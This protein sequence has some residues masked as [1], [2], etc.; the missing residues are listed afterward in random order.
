MNTSVRHPY[1]VQGPCHHD[2]IHSHYINRFGCYFR[3]C[4]CYILLLPAC[5]VVMRVKRQLFDR[6]VMTLG[7]GWHLSDAGWCNSWVDITASKTYPP[8][9]A[10]HQHIFFYLLLLHFP[11]FFSSI[12]FIF[13]PYGL[14]ER[15]G[16]DYFFKAFPFLKKQLFSLIHAAV[17][18]GYY[19][20]NMV[21]PGILTEN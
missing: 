6:Q 8:T 4:W 7:C 10:M 1:K 16:R 2:N 11:F 17:K 13:F 12:V 14:W 20:P 18:I 9:Y 3:E 5:K 19:F 21:W 15:D